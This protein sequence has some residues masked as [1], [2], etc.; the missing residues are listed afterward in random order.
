MCVYTYISSYMYLCV[1]AGHTVEMSGDIEMSPKLV[2]SLHQIPTS[3]LQD[4]KGPH[5][6]IMVACPLG[7]YDVV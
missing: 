6:D 5:T 4:L 3:K 7:A 2:A 1:H